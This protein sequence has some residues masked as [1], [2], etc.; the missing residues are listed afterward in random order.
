MDRRGLNPEFTNGSPSNEDA[1]LANGILRRL[2][3]AGL[4]EKRGQPQ[5]WVFRTVAAMQVGLPMIGG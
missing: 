2:I 1:R 4:V 3:C 5:R